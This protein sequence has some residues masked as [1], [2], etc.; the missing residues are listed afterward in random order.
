MC[1]TQERRDTCKVVEEDRQDIPVTQMS[2]RFYD[3]AIQAAFDE[4]VAS[5]KSTKVK[6]FNEIIGI[7][8]NLPQKFDSDTVENLKALCEFL[9]KIDWNAV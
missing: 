2:L 5:R 6:A 8:L 4:C 7:V 9:E 3:P 1:S